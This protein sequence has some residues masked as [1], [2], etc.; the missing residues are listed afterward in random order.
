MTTSLVFALMRPYK[1]KFYNKLDSIFFGLLAFAYFCIVL[2][3]RLV[4]TG[5]DLT[6]AKLPSVLTFILGIL[7]L[8][9][10]I[11]F[12]FY[13]VIIKH[14]LSHKC[15][16]LCICIS[17]KHRDLYSEL[18]YEVTPIATA[19]NHVTSTLIESVENSGQELDSSLPD[20]IVHPQAYQSL[21][22]SLSLPKHK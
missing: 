1:Q 10:I 22:T 7:P 8:V 12:T 18:D 5:E 17:E 3:Q 15:L 14:K 2:V 9:Y 4:F 19:R 16:G 20:R 21:E 13:W 11:V 6:L